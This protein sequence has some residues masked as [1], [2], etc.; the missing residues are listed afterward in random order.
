MTRSRN[1]ALLDPMTLG[2]SPCNLIFGIKAHLAIDSKT[3]VIHA[4]GLAHSAVVTAA[5]VHDK[6]ALP[7]LLH[8]RERRVCGGS[9]KGRQQ[10]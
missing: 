10:Q 1:L 8:G 5:N 2:K 3:K 6:H 9:G 7:H 4:T